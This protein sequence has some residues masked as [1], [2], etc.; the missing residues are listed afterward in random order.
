M[1]SPFILEDLLYSIVVKYF[2]HLVL[3]LYCITYL[4]MLHSLHELSF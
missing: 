1:L 2:V 4:Q 3:V